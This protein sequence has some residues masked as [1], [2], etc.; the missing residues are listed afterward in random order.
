MFAC[1][2]APPQPP[3]PKLN[4]WGKP[5]KEGIVIPSWVDKIPEAS[6]GKLLA[7]GFSPPTFWP[8]D[9]INA[10]GEDARGK[11]AL[12]MTSHVE[13]LGM[14]TATAN[15]LGGAQIDKEATDVVMQNSRIEATWIDENG[16]RSEPGGVWALASI[17]M[18]SVRG[19]LGAAPDVQP[20][21]TVTPGAR[22]GGA[23]A[24]LD[25]LPAS[26]SK[27]YAAGYSGPTFKP[28]DAVGYAGDNAIDNLA[29]SLRAHV[30]AYTLLVENGSGL[31]VDQFSQTEDPDDAFKDIVKKG[32]KI[33]ATWVDKD[34][35]RPGD[36]PGAVWAL[37]SIDVQSTKGGVKSIENQDLG[38]ALDKQ[39]NPPPDQ[40]E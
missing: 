16:D 14:D 35:L 15:R 29:A 9:A 13:I 6:K 28:D 12:A 24:W 19:H 3:A 4:R 31:S 2:H 33:E 10:A 11:L 7:V 27:V 32:A 40:Q 20:A 1:A 39:G 8:Q 37:A 36:P 5:F 17:E 30:Q 22:P 23:P 25:R 21:S 18:D 34:G 26:R 38:P